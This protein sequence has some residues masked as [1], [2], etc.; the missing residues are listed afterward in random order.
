MTQPPHET[1]TTVIITLRDGSEVRHENVVH[2]ISA[3][4]CN[5][6]MII[7]ERDKP[8]RRWIYPL[9]PQTEVV[10]VELTPS[11]IERN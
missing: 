6:V 1:F 9:A 5:A 2:A 10:M 7:E 11:L 4:P 3:T 8:R